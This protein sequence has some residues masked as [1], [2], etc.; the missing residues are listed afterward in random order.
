MGSKRLTYYFTG[1]LWNTGKYFATDL[2]KALEIMN[3]Y[4]HMYSNGY[5]EGEVMRNEAGRKI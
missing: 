2:S 1:D 4:G 3:T 5:S